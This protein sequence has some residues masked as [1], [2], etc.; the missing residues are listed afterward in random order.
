MFYTTNLIK[1]T[2]SISQLNFIYYIMFCL[3][4]GK[5]TEASIEIKA[6]KFGELDAKDY[7]PGA[8]VLLEE[9]CILINLIVLQNPLVLVFC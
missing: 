6:K 9:V 7:I 3:F 2:T 1:L 4:K 8:E 5:P